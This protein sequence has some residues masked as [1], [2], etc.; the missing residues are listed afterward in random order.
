MVDIQSATTEIRQG[1]KGRKI[2]TTGQKYNPS[3]KNFKTTYCSAY[4]LGKKCNWWRKYFKGWL[5][6]KHKLHQ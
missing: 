4:S 1:K 3:H 6:P 2:E 5:P